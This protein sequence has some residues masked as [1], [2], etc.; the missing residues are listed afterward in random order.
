MDLRHPSENRPEDTRNVIIFVVLAVLLWVGF[1]YFYQQP[2]TRALAEQKKQQEQTIKTLQ[3]EGK[4]PVQRSRDE[5][6]AAA[7]RVSFEGARIKGSLSTQGARID[8]II[9]KDHFEDKEKTKPITLFSPPDTAFTQ[10]AE[11][12]WIAEGDGVVLPDSNT[13]WQKEEIQPDHIRFT[14]SNGQGL[15]FTRD[16]TVDE[17]FLVTVKQTVENNSAAQVRLYPYGKIVQRGLS[18]YHE[19][20]AVWHE[21]PMGYIGGDLHETKFDKILKRKIEIYEAMT[22]WIGIGQKYWF[23]GF[24]PGSQELSQYRFIGERSPIKEQKDLYQVDMRGLLR[25]IPAGSKTEVTTHLY[26]GA[27]E[28]PII[29]NYEK[30]L[31]V[32]H[33]DLIVDFGWF[34]FLTRPFMFLLN[35]FNSWVGNFGIAILMLTVIL[36][37]AVFPLANTSYRSFAGMKKIGPK[38]QELKTKFGDDKAKMQQELVKLYQ[39]EGVNPAA[40]C[41]PILLQIPIFFSMFKVVSIN[42]EMRHEP[43]FGWIQDLTAPDPTTIFNLFGLIPWDPPSFL[44]IGAWPCLMLLFMLIQQKLNPPPEDEMQRQMMAL[45]PFFMCFILAKFAAGLVIYWTFSNF[46]SIIQQMVI[47]KSMN[48]EIHLFSP[49]NWVPKKRVPKDGKDLPPVEGKAERVYEKPAPKKADEPL[50]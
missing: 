34:Y 26:A 40:G 2:R 37:A 41:L 49:D 36:R 14:W 4:L 1:D 17:N 7:T 15:D 33:L 46:L 31:N 3:A 18:K 27:K 9:L 39:Q 19:Q 6:I 8:D 16:V 38:V 29:E 5:A 13:V 23:A 28:V 48:V 43:F 45:M 10:F 44:H 12:G 42:I 25:E 30:A 50:F 21:G 47:M 20:G 35:L 24:I 22:G 32:G 11:T